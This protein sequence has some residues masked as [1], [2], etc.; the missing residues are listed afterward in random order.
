MK[1]KD[2]TPLLTVLTPSE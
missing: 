2:D 1:S